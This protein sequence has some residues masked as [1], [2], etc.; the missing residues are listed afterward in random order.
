MF[1]NKI[2]LFFFI[3]VIICLI[4]LAI[5]KIN[6]P[7]EQVAVKT[8]ETVKESKTPKKE[9]NLIDGKYSTT[10]IECINSFLTKP[11]QLARLGFAISPDC[12]NIAYFLKNNDKEFVAVNDKKGKEYD[13]S[14]I[15]SEVLF[16]PD[17]K[18][19]GY[20]AQK[21]NK[22][23]AVVDGNEGQEYDRIFRDV[24]T[25]SPDSK[26]VAYVAQKGDKEVAIIDGKEDAE[27][28]FILKGY[29]FFSPDSKNTAYCA[30][31]EKIWHKNRVLVMNGKEKWDEGANIVRGRVFFSP[32]SKRLAYIAR[33][34]LKMY[35]VIDGIKQKKFE[36]SPFLDEN[37]ILD[38]DNF[39][40]E[41]SVH[42]YPKTNLLWDN[43]DPKSKE[44]IGNW[45]PGK[46]LDGK[47]K[48]TIISGLN[49]VIKKKEFYQPTV[50][51]DVKLDEKYRDILSLGLAMKPMPK[52]KEEFLNRLMLE[53]TF[54]EEIEKSRVYYPKHN[55]T[56]SPDS[57]H[58]AYEA[59]SDKK[60]TMMLDQTS[61]KI[62]ED[63]GPPVFS[64]NSKHL[65][66]IAG[67]G[68]KQFVVVDGVEGKK[69]DAI[70]STPKYSPDSKHIAYSATENGKQFMVLDG[71]EGK[72][73]DCILMNLTV[74][75]TD[76]KQDYFRAITEVTFLKEI[77][78]YKKKGRLRKTVNDV[79]SFSADGKRTAYAVRDGDKEYVVLDGKEEKK[80]DR[81]VLL[82]VFSPDGKSTAYA[83]RDDGEEFVVINGHPMK[84]FDYIINRG[85]GRIIFDSPNEL[86]YLA[87]TE[88]NIYLVEE[89]IKKA[90]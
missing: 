73:H 40:K 81:I 14:P 34:D 45:K 57:R 29:V 85:N 75:R 37:S 84:K 80:Y 62:Y 77:E 69:Y 49:E 8:P 89:K 54:P 78:Q 88:N 2:K 10:K 44:I 71:K 23:I 28:T 59:R 74:F 87:I 32:N 13:I 17:S 18:R 66:Y 63:I 33:E 4:A 26:R 70:N 16:S 39:L 11:G 31:K 1:R 47:S 21:G 3:A 68:K 58:I 12:R 19:V 83:V 79:L 52:L 61:G 55:M 67:E 35:A 42:D 22:R 60:W 7:R 64:P 25:F 9:V 27:Y 82:P 53:A 24:I 90:D 38:W 50:F 46:S 48:A 51:S 65:C 30:D 36:A 43:L 6:T 86:H 20:I 41:T 76:S 72:K 56:F 5:W 15:T